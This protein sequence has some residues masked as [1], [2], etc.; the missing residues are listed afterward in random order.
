[1]PRDKSG[2]ALGSHA[3][4]LD[5]KEQNR[6]WRRPKARSPKEDI[7]GADGAR[8]GSMRC[9]REERREAAA[10]DG[11]MEL[12]RGMMSRRGPVA[13]AS[14]CPMKESVLVRCKAAR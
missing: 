14:A 9:R 12:W 6:A 10:E 7:T 4:V 3:P 8:A 5:R 11:G 1:V 2:T 13:A